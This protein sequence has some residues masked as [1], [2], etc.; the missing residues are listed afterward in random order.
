MNIRQSALKHESSHCGR[1]LNHQA[2][3]SAMVY[4]NI[5]GVK[6]CGNILRCISVRAMYSFAEKSHI[7]FFFI[8]MVT[9]NSELLG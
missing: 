9:N 7:I 3:G 1:P 8:N 5:V 4:A 6:V 2:L